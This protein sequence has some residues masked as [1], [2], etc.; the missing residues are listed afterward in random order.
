MDFRLA[1]G[2]RTV[3]TGRVRAAPLR[4]VRQGRGPGEGARR[5]GPAGT[6]A[7][8]YGLGL[9]N[10]RTGRPRG[11]LWRRAQAALE[12]RGGPGAGLYASAISAADAASHTWAGLFHGR[13]SPGSGPSW[14]RRKRGSGQAS[15]YTRPMAQTCRTYPVRPGA[16]LWGGIR[17]GP[18]RG[19]RSTASPRW[20]EQHTDHCLQAPS[21]SQLYLPKG[22]LEHAIR[23][24][25]P[26]PGP[27]ACL[28]QPC[29]PGLKLSLGSTSTLQGRLTEG[30][31]A[32]GGGQ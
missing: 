28:R 6:G 8:Q 17:R 27:V 19:G 22:D 31:A 13:Q 3:T 10:G 4:L 11:R 2:R 29:C 12:H 15:G 18:P 21:F 30:R 1:L 32:G 20:K 26:G 7:R 14:V 16:E 23:G 25:R 24:V 9:V 5:S